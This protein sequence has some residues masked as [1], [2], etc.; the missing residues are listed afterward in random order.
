[1]FGLCKQHNHFQ[2]QTPPAIASTTTYQAS[3][4]SDSVRSAK[5]QKTATAVVSD[6]TDV[7]ET[8]SLSTVKPLIAKAVAFQEKDGV[9]WFQYQLR[10]VT[11][12]CSPWRDFINVIVLKSPSHFLQ[13]Y[14]SALSLVNE[15]RSRQ[16]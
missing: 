6:S 7:Q 4:L 8:P 13:L 9:Q 16:G 12:G 10:K 11:E 15:R 14:S 5:M 1:M 2:M 3:K